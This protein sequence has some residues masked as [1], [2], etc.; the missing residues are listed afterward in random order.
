MQ[1]IK[2]SEHPRISIITPSFNQGKYIEETILSV[3]NQNYPN[4]EYIIIDGGS[5]DETVDII[6][7]YQ[8]RISYWVSEKDNGQTHAVNKGLNQATGEIIGWIN[9][10]DTYVE[11]S[12]IKVAR[13]FRNNT[14]AI[15]VHGERIMIDS[16]S[17]VSGW[18]SNK[19]FNPVVSNFNVCSETA[20]WRS[21]MTKGVRLKE[22]LKF[23]MDLEFFCRLYQ[24][25][26]FVKLRCYLGRFRC[27]PENKSSTI[28][29]IGR[30]EGEREWNA[31][32]GP[33]SYQPNLTSHQNRPNYFSHSLA[34]VLY[35]IEIGIPYLIRRLVHNQRGL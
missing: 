8:D 15:L 16:N 3:L 2:K 19:P 28:S 4:L 31:I 7:K 25:G 14:D 33:G 35:P 27:Y 5:T 11:G 18:T 6:K 30:E 34:I 13:A 9:S 22:D 32:F 20:F 21:S 10:D 1:N 29:H 26:R 17:R 24:I 12:F 23:A